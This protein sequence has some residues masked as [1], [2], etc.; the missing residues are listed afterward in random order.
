[1]K[2][3]FFAIRDGSKRKA[4]PCAFM[5][6]TTDRG[7]RIEIQKD[8]S[9]DTV[10]A[11]FIPFIEKRDFCLDS[12]LSAKWVGERIPPT[13]RQNLG[14]ILDAHSLSEYSEVELLRSGR[15]ESSQDSFIV[16]EIDSESYAKRTVDRASVRRKAL[17]KAIKERRGNL[18]LSQRELADELGIS[19]PA[20]SKIEAGAANITF[21][22]LTEIDDCLSGDEPSF[23]RIPAANLWTRERSEMLESLRIMDPE[24]AIFYAQMIDLIEGYSNDHESCSGASL[25]KLFFHDLV[26]KLTSLMAAYDM[27]GS[28]ET[29]GGEEDA[30]RSRVEGLAELASS[31]DWKKIERSRLI[32]AV[33]MLE[34]VQKDCVSGFL[35]TSSELLALISIANQVDRKGEFVSPLNEQLEELAKLVDNPTLYSLV[36][37][38]I[39][40]PN[41]KDDLSRYEYAHV[42][43]GKNCL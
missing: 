40:N 13:G 4:K 21:D 43:I 42:D 7:F 37:R 26:A 31:L 39:R 28:S 19:Q 30:V 16:Q 11:F 22:L 20:L 10:P 8:A 6:W 2:E 9:V 25:L 32:D 27:R 3:A 41:W 12:E 29:T 34:A 23:L 24:Y 35:E 14:E 36:M 15:G 33:L 38:E 18:G 5:K 17:G 1:M